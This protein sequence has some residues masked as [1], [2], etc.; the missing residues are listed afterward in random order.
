ML[1]KGFPV[2]VD[3]ADFAYDI[4]SVIWKNSNNALSKYIC[5]D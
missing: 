2:V 4:T 3:Y 1:I 5:M